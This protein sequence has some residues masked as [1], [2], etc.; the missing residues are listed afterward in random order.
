MCIQN[1]FLFSNDIILKG[2]V[3][4]SRT[5]IFVQ[6]YSRVCKLDFRIGPKKI[7]LFELYSMT[8]GPWYSDPNGPG[9]GLGPL[10]QD[11]GLGA[12]E[13]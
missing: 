11:Y 3:Q 10:T 13:T 5:S 2:D 1:T 8:K 7:A 12:I 6:M 9:L 4:I